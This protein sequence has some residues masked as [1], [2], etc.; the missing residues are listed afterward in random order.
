MLKYMFNKHM[1]KVSLYKKLQLSIS[2]IE[3]VYAYWFNSVLEKT[4]LM[5]WHVIYNKILTIHDFI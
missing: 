5:C 4:Y 1:A 3:S 2:R